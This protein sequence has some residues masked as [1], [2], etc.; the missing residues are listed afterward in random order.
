[1]K[2]FQ[3][4]FQK[5]R[6]TLF[7]FFSLLVFQ[8][9]SQ[10][11]IHT[12]AFVPGEKISYDAYYNWGLLWVRA[13]QVEFTVKEKIFAGKNAYFF[14]SKGWSIPT[15]DWLFKVRDT[16]RSYC[17]QQT[18]TSLWYERK[19]SEGNYRAYEE[20]SFDHVKNRIFSKTENSKRAFSSK[21][22]KL[23]PCTYDLISLIYYARSLDFQHFSINEKIPLKTIIDN[24]IFNIYIR[25]VGK[26]VIH[27]KKKKL[28]S[29]YKF[30]AMMVEGTIFKSGEDLT[31]WVTDDSNRIPVLVEAKILIGSVKAYLTGTSGLKN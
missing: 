25:Y 19:T 20:Y 7:I 11:K 24:E 22:L 8:A 2:Y 30:K 16:F 15:Y 21:F 18:F 4:F 1:V 23:E 3:L 27:D 31:V 5:G 26:E 6:I 14:E 10:C 9:R 13:G 28:Y 29:C 12:I 17:D